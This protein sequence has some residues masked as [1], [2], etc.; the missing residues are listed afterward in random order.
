MTKEP[1]KLKDLLPDVIKPGGEIE[2]IALIKKEKMSRQEKSDEL[3]KVFNSLKP[4]EKFKAVNNQIRGL[5]KT[6]DTVMLP[7]RVIAKDEP[8][9]LYIMVEEL[10]SYAGMNDANFARTV[11]DVLI[12]TYGWMALQDF[13]LFFRKIKSGLYG[14]IYGKMNGMWIAG[15]IKNFQQSVQYNITKDQEAVHFE[16]KRLDGARDL[17]HYYDDVMPEI[18]E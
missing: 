1:K 16:Y 15:K 18:I 7:G 17:D 14:E 2:S 4:P 10:F 8:E 12:E 5:V 6:H 3:V 9:V 13:A 11:T